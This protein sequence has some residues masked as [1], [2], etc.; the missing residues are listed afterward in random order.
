MADI[1]QDLLGL[2]YSQNFTFQGMQEADIDLNLNPASNTYATVYSK[3]TDG[4]DPIPNATVKLF[5]NKGLPFKHTLTDALGEYSMDGIPAGT[6]SL[7]TVRNGFRLSDTVGVTLSENDTTEINFVCTPDA[8]LSLGAIAGILT[9][10][11]HE[12]KNEPLSGAKITLPPKPTQR[13]NICS[14]VSTAGSIWSRQK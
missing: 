10:E 1:K 5:D 6:Y 11:E 3:V 8:T 2:Q 9:I 14:A 7:G 13:E 4:T 12:G